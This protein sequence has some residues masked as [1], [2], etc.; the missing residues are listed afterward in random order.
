MQVTHGCIR[1]FPE[2]IEELYELV[3]VNTRVN[4]VDQTTKVGWQRG[5]L[6]V[7]R[8]APLEGTN[9]PAH[10]DPQEMTKLLTA[11]LRGRPPVTID[12]PSAQ[13]AFLLA[14]GVPVPLSTP[15]RAPG[16]ASAR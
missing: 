14:T 16:M 4:L 12:W 2:D 15:V 11:A 13:Q 3:G 8:Q 9:D 5:T 7:E 1:L 6:Y 10:E